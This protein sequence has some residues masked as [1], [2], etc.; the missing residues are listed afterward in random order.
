MRSVS[1]VKC[2]DPRS[3]SLF[4]RR[5]PRRRQAHR[6]NRRRS[7][8]QASAPAACSQCPHMRDT[9]LR[10][11][12]TG[13][14]SV[15]SA[16]REHGLPRSKDGADDGNNLQTAHA[17]CNL[18][19]ENR[20]GSI[21]EQGLTEQPKSRAPEEQQLIPPG[22]PAGAH[23][24]RV[25]AEGVV[26]PV[27]LT[28][29]DRR[30]V[31]T[32]HAGQ[33]GRPLAVDCRGRRGLAGQRVSMYGWACHRQL[34][35]W[36]RDAARSAA[37]S[38]NLADRPQRAALQAYDPLVGGNSPGARPNAS[39]TCRSGNEP[40]RPTSC[41]PRHRWP[42]SVAVLTRHAPTGSTSRLVRASRIL[43]VYRLLDNW[44]GAPKN[45][46]EH[47]DG[48]HRVAADANP[49]PTVTSVQ[50]IETDVAVPDRHPVRDQPPVG[51][52]GSRA[53]TPA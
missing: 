20:A 49:R 4:Q 32:R 37:T 21:A 31:A 28:A 19:T 27:G 45:R 33:T 48:R 9:R 13:S 23:T 8:L 51:P 44:H 22:K 2:S 1:H 35:A 53:V 16:E 7:R 14:R 40:A 41:E 10:V 24:V 18:R 34:V 39:T 47:H 52:R 11:G 15:E 5:L 42:D 25:R 26:A 36:M 17:V 38:S 43:V 29:D 50:R 3:F 46:R 30:G 12:H 6:F